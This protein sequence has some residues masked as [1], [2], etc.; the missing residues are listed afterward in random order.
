[1]SARPTSQHNGLFAASMAVSLFVGSAFLGGSAIA[2]EA[3]S[4]VAGSSEVTS[5]ANISTTSSGATA[6][7][8]ATTSSAVTTSSGATTSLGASTTGASTS[9]GGAESSVGASTTSGSSTS[10]G[11]SS[12]V[13]TVPVT[14]AV[15]FVAGPVLR[16]GSKGAAVETMEK[17]LDLLHYD[18]GK[19]DG[20]F[21]SQTW[22]GLMAFQKLNRLRRTALFDTATQKALSTAVIP[23]GLIPNGG[24]P[25]VEVDISRQVLLYFD[26]FGLNRVVAVSSGS[27]KKYCETSKKDGSKNCGDARTPRGNYRIDR[28]IKGKRES[29][30]GTLYSPMYFNGGFAIHGSP[31]IPAGPA[32]H[33]CVRISNKTADWMFDTV[34]NGTPVYIFD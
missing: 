29:A 26:E 7:S 34:K 25:R 28:R 1:M 12:T 30:L 11:V 8:G 10:S 13:A 4:S 16:L 2:Q 20:R 27:E 23:G 21:D 32:S 15:P 17:K 22:Q 33:G 14:T 9:A 18:V 5:T 31:S 6:S 19:V 3:T 24:L